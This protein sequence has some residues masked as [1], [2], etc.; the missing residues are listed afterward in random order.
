M[1]YTSVTGEKTP[2]TVST[3]PM[4]L[5]IKA[6]P[7]SKINQVIIAA[8]NIPII[9]IKAPARDGEAND[10]LIFFLSEKLGLPKSKI[11]IASG[12]SSPFKKIEIDADEA[13]VKKKLGIL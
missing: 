12:L 11:K 9:K 8:D 5:H 10:E 4:H 7:G 1:R 6:K 13:F 3:V 2:T